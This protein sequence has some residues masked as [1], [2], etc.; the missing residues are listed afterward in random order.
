MITSSPFLMAEMRLPCK[1]MNAY[2]ALTNLP[3]CL[4][5]TQFPILNPLGYNQSMFV[6]LPPPVWVVESNSL[7]HLARTLTLQPRLAVDTESNSLHA[8]REQVCLIQFSVPSA[9]YLIDPLVLHELS[10]LIPIFYNPQIEKVFHAAEYDLIC[11]KRDFSIT[12]SNIFDTMQAARIL[13]YKQVGLD[14]MLFEKLGIALNK[15]YQ[16]AD[17]GERPLTQE[18]LDYAR[19]DTHHLLDLRDC[20]QTELQT[21][22][23]WDL[24]HEEFVRLALGNGAKKSE[25]P[26]WL[27]VKGTQHL[28]KR[29]L[30]ILQE[31][32]SWREIQAEKMGRPV[33]KVMDDSRLVSI[34]LTAPK[35]QAGLEALNLTARQVHIFGD[36]ILQAISRGR[37]AAPLSRPLSIR[38][39]PVVLNRL[40][41]L[42]NWR[43]G[44][45][46]KI[47]I[48][49]D[50]ILPKAWM[51]AIA[52]KNP[53]TIKELSAIMP[54]SPWRLATFGAEILKTLHP[55]RNL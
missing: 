45:A 41:A 55:K 53:E 30:A 51:H 36:D 23:R 14:A 35:T 28:T 37:N 34:A 21:S 54:R 10:P 38:P 32:C 40:N 11:L 48:E 13:G 39:D 49:S 19:L 24:A 20:L 8:Y 2:K 46:Q 52:I 47:G 29:Q 1:L 42:S 3:P 7:E 22:G 6:P 50:L 44:A 4:P 18:M 15:R 26:A 31:L 12:V 25:I 17:W 5:V 27:R 9:D 16:K 33:F 43:K